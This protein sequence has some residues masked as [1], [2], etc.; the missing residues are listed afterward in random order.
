MT[1]ATLT[2]KFTE[3]S[4][5]THAARV[6]GGRL[7]PQLIKTPQL[8]T[9]TT[10]CVL[11]CADAR[12]FASCPPNA[13]RH[14]GLRWLKRSH[15]NSSGL[16]DTTMLL[17]LLVKVAKAAA[18]TFEKSTHSVILCG[19]LSSVPQDLECS[20]ATASSKACNWLATCG[21][22]K[23]LVNLRNGARTAAIVEAA[24]RALGLEE[25]CL[26]A[27]LLKLLERHGQHYTG[28]LFDG[29]ARPQADQEMLEPGLLTATS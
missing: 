19:P 24:E 18:P 3:A 7:S 26:P 15:H 22:A 6:R 5:K 28:R 21:I 11:A 25:A 20:K 10:M 1:I 23:L 9:W 4:R 13:L 16:F 8:S 17:V 29:A 12:S 14:L 2:K 27:A